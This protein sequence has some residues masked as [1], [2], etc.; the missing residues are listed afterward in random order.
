MS[1][2]S[3]R[4]PIKSYADPRIE[5]YEPTDSNP[6]YLIVGY[7]ARGRRVVNTTGGRTLRS[8]Q[9]KA[10]KVAVGLRRVARD[11]SHDPGRV[12][13]HAEAKKWLAAIH[14]S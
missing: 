11:R 13:V 8:A 12:L 5:I 2:R 14:K 10:A 3:R 9:N 1:N 7:N 4:G 6:Y